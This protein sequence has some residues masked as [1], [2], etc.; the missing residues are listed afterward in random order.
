MKRSYRIS[1]I[2]FSIIFTL[3]IILLIIGYIYP[4]SFFTNQ[5]AIRDYLKRFGI[6]SPLV[7]VVLSII[8]VVITPLNHTFI[9][10][11]GG[12]IFGF[13]WGI[14]LIWLG[15]T[16]GHIINFYLGRL[17]GGK[18]IN[19]FVSPDLI[20]KYHNFFE[21]KTIIL[22]VVYFVPFVIPQDD[23][24]YLVGLST[25]STRKFILISSLGN[26]GTSLVLSYLGSGISSRNPLYIIFAV[27]LGI[28]ILVFRQI[29]RSS[30]SKKV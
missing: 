5:D 8:P 13:E 29:G 11:A 15:K 26:I 30:L 10:L 6:W 7:F 18:V 2:I 23:I 19:R 24:S 14:F 1:I 20:E 9:G 27:I 12:Y 25:I 4:D 3:P 21:N 17:L 22:F 28:L 16:I